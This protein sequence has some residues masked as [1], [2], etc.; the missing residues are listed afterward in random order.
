M[1]RNILNV[2][3]KAQNFVV[4]TKSCNLTKLMEMPDIVKPEGRRGVELERN[5]VNSLAHVIHSPQPLEYCT[6]DES[7]FKTE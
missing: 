5:D 7:L 6:L 4:A 2:K 3:L 1:K